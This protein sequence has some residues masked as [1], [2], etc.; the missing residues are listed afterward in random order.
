MAFSPLISLS[1]LSET[2]L[3]RISNSSLSI[4]FYPHYALNQIIVD[5]QDMAQSSSSFDLQFEGSNGWTNWTS[6]VANNGLYRYSTQHPTSALT[7]IGGIYKM[8]I[9][10]TGTPDYIEV[11]TEVQQNWSI[12]E[13]PNPAQNM[14][15]GFNQIVDTYSSGSIYCHEGID[16]QGDENIDGDVVATN[17]GVAVYKEIG[18]EF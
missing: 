6:V 15:H 9:S 7:N 17:K 12:S 3:G 8:R 4:R 1:F 13:S 16:I 2:V 5:V 10:L 14:L 18:I 11:Q